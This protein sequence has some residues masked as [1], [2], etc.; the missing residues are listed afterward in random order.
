MPKERSEPA[1]QRQDETAPHAAKVLQKPGASHIGLVPFAWF[2]ERWCTGAW[3]GTQ[4]L[5]TPKGRVLEVKSWQT[6]PYLTAEHL[7]MLF[8]DLPGEDVPGRSGRPATCRIAASAVRLQAM[9][10]TARVAAA[11]PDG[12]ASSPLP[13]AAAGSTQRTVRQALRYVR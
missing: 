5:A 9:A 10:C 4:K 2:I 7:D 12:M 1:K 13:V 3:G 6:L 8:G 11:L